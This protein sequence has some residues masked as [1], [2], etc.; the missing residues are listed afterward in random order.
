LHLQN[1]VFLNFAR[2]LGPLHFRQAFALSFLLFL[3]R[4]HWSPTPTNGSVTWKAGPLR[5]WSASPTKSV[6]AKPSATF[7]LSERIKGYWDR[8]ATEIELVALNASDRVIRLGSCKRSAAELVRDVPVFCGNIE[9]FLHQFPE[10]AGWRVECVSLAPHVPQDV[11][12]EI[13]R[14]GSPLQDL[15]D[16]TASL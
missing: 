7:P 2:V 3:L 13:E 10:Y 4:R 1:Q 12:Q 6:A 11:R 16:L 5:S 14:H 9:R 8:S 15:N